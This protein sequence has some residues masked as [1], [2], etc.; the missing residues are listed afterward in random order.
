MIVWEQ[1]PELLEFA[2]RVLE[3]EFKPEQCAWIG[4]LNPDGSPL[5]VVVFDRFSPFNCEMSIASDG[6]RKWFS[7]EFVGVCFRYAFKQMG[8]KRVTVVVEETNAKS[9]K[10]CRQLGYVEEARLVQWYG[11]VDGIAFRMLKDE[12]RWL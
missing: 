10:M 4:R 1:R 3:V 11:D 8:L 6:T 9:L 12:C 2:N 7:R 5:A